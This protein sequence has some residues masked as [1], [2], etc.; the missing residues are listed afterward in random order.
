M[1]ARRASPCAQL[2]HHPQPALSPLDLGMGRLDQGQ[3]VCVRQPPAICCVDT[4]LGPVA[5]DTD[6]ADIT[7]RV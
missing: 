1:L 4:L 7:Q 5:A 3:Q 2:M 6:P